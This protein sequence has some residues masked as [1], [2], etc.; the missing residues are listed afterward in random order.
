MKKN[1]ENRCSVG[2]RE[3][4]RKSVKDLCWTDLKKQKNKKKQ[5]TKKATN[6]LCF[7]SNTERVGF[8]ALTEEDS[9]RY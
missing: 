1:E 4:E 2:E 3:R 8:F 6:C 7:A 5:K 9:Q